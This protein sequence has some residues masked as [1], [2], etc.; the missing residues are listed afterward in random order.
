MQK[1]KL[2]AILSFCFQSIFI[3]TA[4]AGGAEKSPSHWTG[5][6]VGAT[7]GGVFSDFNTN[8]STQAGG[9]FDA[10]QANAINNAGNLQIDANGFLAGVEGGYNWQYQH[11]LI[12]LETDLQSLSINDEKN[13]GAVPYPNVA[14][15][16]F[17]VTVYGNNNW[18]LTVRPRLGFATNNWL[19]YVTGGLGLTLFQSDFVFSR[20]ST[21][22]GNVDF[23]ESKKVDRVKPGYVIGAGVEGAL[24]HRLSFKVEYQH[25]KFNTIKANNQ[26][27]NNPAGNQISSTVNLKSNVV[28]I[29][30]N[31]HFNNQTSGK[32]ADPLL[33][34]DFFDPENWE[35]EMGGRL[36]PSTGLDGAPQPL[37][38]PSNVGDRLASRLTFSD[39]TA[40]SAETFARIEHATGL[41]L[42]GYLG[43]GSV[44]SGHLN[45]EDFPAGG[46]YSN[47]LSDVT[48]NLSYA[49]VD[50]GY[51][52]LKTLAGKT[53]IFIGY[54]YYA[55]NLNANGCQQ[56]AGSL[57]CLPPG[58]FGNFL[59]ITEDDY[60]NSLR[61]GFL[62]QFDLTRRLSLTSEA[63]Y[64]PVVHFTGTDVHDARELIGPESSKRGDGAMLQVILQYQ[65]N[66]YWN[67]GVGGRYWLWNMH[68][69]SVIFDF[70]GAGGMI[71]VPGRFTADRYGGF[72]QLSYQH[73]KSND[74]DL[75]DTPV[76][77]QGI[78]IGG[79][80]GGEWGRSAWS[81]PF[82]SSTAATGLPNVAGFG[83]KIRSSGPLGG[84]VVNFDW[85]TNKFVYGFGGTFSGAD[86]RGENTAFSGIG[87]IN[88]RMVANYLATIF[89]K[90]GVAFNNSLLYIDGGA[91]ALN[92]K[93]EVNGN[94]SILS[95]GKEDDNATA[96]GWTVGFGVEYALDKHWTTNVEYDRVQIPACPLSFPSVVTINTQQIKAN[97]GMNIF[98]LGLSYRFD[99]L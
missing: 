38:N 43:A 52:F 1:C 33:S 98:K 69:G 11:L 17:V 66:D 23:F 60:Y 22:T 81:D 2:I 76:S 95:L 4:I 96:W 24:T 88:A 80:I 97:Q 70:L 79:T 30:L 72:V 25:E 48:G 91:A 36:F 34:S 51:S 49:T 86:I 20:E 83:G 39:L 56:L 9:S 78:F 99:V 90:L 41:F 26:A 92:T 18:L 27:T 37:L 15:R 73:K 3:S 61:V 59:G 63:A 29:G 94:T 74:E 75:F 5:F 6:Y 82:V 44:T 55:Q 31:Y 16:Q 87:G 58:S 89:A 68:N 50:L 42:K 77:W 10:A 65:L 64:L 21:Q 32:F 14:A 67:L 85:Q 62:S 53:G 8:T 93:Y 46:A 7:M 47:T 84:A 57:V 12:G 28:R 13:S 35:F 19:V 45:D 71:S 40:V 54:N